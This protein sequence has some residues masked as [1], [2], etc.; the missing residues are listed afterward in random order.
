MKNLF[1]FVLLILS[2][3]LDCFTASL[4]EGFLIRN[5]NYRRFL[6][7]GF[8][9][10]LVQSLFFILGYVSGKLSSNFLS[11]YD[12]W[13]AFLLL[14]VI[15]FHMIYEEIRGRSDEENAGFSKNIKTLAG[16]AGAVSIDAFAVGVVSFILIKGWV[17]FTFLVFVLTFLLS[18]TG[19]FL[20]SRFSFLS[21]KL[22]FTQALG[23]TILILIGLKILLEH[24]GVF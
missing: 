22:K 11:P 12:H 3:N 16:V 1:Y 13:V 6:S 17:L 23:G 9:F 18:L 21:K 20:G 19:V 8:V 4:T 7:I 14:L 5:V 2:I 10:G 15:G 24:L